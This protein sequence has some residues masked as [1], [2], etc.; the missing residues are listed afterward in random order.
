MDNKMETQKVTLENLPRFFNEKILA[1]ALEVSVSW[2]GRARM[3]RI[4]PPFIKLGK[5]KACPVR[6][7]RKDVLEWI[8]SCKVIPPDHPD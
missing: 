2:C 3:N 7:S 1:E 6:Y 5:G 4:G 8:E